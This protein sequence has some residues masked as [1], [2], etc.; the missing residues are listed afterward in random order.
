MVEAMMEEYHNDVWDIVPKPGS[1]SVVSSKWI[2]KIKH[3]VDGRKDVWLKD[4]LR[5]RELIMKR[6][7]LQES[8]YTSIRTIMAVSSMMK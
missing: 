5:E 7:L 6:H 4:S 8:R 1:K 3:V 2:Y